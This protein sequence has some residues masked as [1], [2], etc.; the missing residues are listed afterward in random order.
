MSS[1]II[2]IFSAGD[3][4]EQIRRGADVLRGGGLVVLPTETVYGAA[5]LLTNA[6]ARQRMGDL[7]GGAA[8]RPFTVHLARPSDALQYLGDVSELGHRLMKKLWPGP[9]GLNFEVRADRRR[10]VAE[11]F[12]IAEADLYDSAGITL[13]CPDHI[14]ATDMIGSVEGPVALTVP[15]AAAGYSS[16]G[17]QIAEKL[18]GQVD[19][20]FEAGPTPYSKPS[21]LLKVTGDKYEVVRQGMYDERIIEKLLRT[22]I[23]FVCSGNTCRPDG[24]GNHSSS[25][26]GAGGRARGGSGEEGNQCRVCRRLCPAGSEA[27]PQAVDAVKSLGADLSS[28][29]SR[30]LTIELIH[31]ADMIYTMGR[32]HAQAVEAMV[33]R[34]RK[35]SPRSIP[36]VIST[37]RSAETLCCTRTWPAN[38][39]V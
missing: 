1:P 11:G 14:V 33:H 36:L 29:R 15:P 30:P 28:H 13:R 25:A 4:D 16:T 35:R 27:T 8:D 31:Q 37:T 9:V 10:E 26:C 6:S 20:I 7:R 23:L 12:G 3:Y 32:S 22:T 19:L 38:F 21:T 2:S 24:G 39:A 18:D 34:R 17:E 5:G